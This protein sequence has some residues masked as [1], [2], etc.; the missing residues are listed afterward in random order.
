MRA[1]FD[2][3]C[4]CTGRDTATSVAPSETRNPRRVVIELCRLSGVAM[5]LDPDPR[6]HRTPRS[7]AGGRATR[8]PDPL[9]R[10]VRR[11][12]VESELQ[13]DRDLHH[14]YSMTRSARSSSDGGIVRPRAFA[15]LRLIASSNFVGCSMGKSAGRAPL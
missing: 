4:A 9:Q 1:V 15:V 11:P 8:A 3:C 12:P 6:V 10:E 5:P 14:G 2:G 13:S 7:A